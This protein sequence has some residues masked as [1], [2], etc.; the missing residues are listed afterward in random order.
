MDIWR[1]ILWPDCWIF[2]GQPSVRHN[3][4]DCNR[5]QWHYLLDQISRHNSRFIFDK[6]FFQDMF[7][8]L[9]NL[10]NCSKFTY[11]KSKTEIN[12]L[13]VSF[14]CNSDSAI[15]FWHYKKPSYTG[16]M[17]HSLLNQPY[18]KFDTALSLKN[19]SSMHVFRV[20]GY[21]KAVRAVSAVSRLRRST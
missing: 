17:I 12:F 14:I 9:K 10:Q 3:T 4:R 13:D 7:E 6:H 18:T 15:H 11:E 5:I 16:K 1:K 8:F 21:V 2:H 20:L 19:Q